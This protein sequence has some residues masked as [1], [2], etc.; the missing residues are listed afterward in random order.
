MVSPSWSALAIF[1][2]GFL[3]NRLPET[4]QGIALTEELPPRVSPGLD[5]NDLV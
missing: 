5:N 2:P 1:G 3:V 4:L